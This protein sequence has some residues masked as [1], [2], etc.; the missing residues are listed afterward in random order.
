MFS[1]TGLDL[2][3][4]FGWIVIVC[5]GSITV[6]FLVKL[7]TNRH[8]W[9]NEKQSGGA[10]S[11]EIQTRRDKEEFELQHH[12]ADFQACQDAG[13]ESPGELLSAYKTLLAKGKISSNQDQ[14]CQD[15][16]KLMDLLKDAESCISDY[17]A[18]APWGEYDLRILNDLRSVIE[19]AGSKNDKA[20]QND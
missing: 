20:M 19:T 7:L 12:R 4:V 1:T 5:I 3:K 9:R 17:H 15:N 16:E 11:S 10:K 18:G 2:L 6:F 13:F 14:S 8:K